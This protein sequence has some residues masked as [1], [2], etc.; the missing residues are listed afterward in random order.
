MRPVTL[1]ILSFAAG[2][3]D[4]YLRRDLIP[5][6]RHLKA[7]P[8]RPAAVRMRKS[9][10]AG[11][12]GQKLH[13]VQAHFFLDD[14]AQIVAECRQT[15]CVC[16]RVFPNQGEQGLIK[17]LLSIQQHVDQVGR[18]HLRAARPL[19]ESDLFNER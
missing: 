11:G 13:C 16:T 10:R 9:G 1:N 15:G 8:S 12:K 6:K 7:L 5:A 14:K 2:N 19:H 18:Q 3:S 17:D 4:L